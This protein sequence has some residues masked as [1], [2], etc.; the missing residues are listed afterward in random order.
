MNGRKGGTM[1]TS[2]NGIKLIEQFEGCKL[3]AYKDSV[4]IW[5]IGYGHTKGVTKGMKITQA[6]AN[7]YLRQDVSTAESA[8]NS[9]NSIYNFSQNQFDA[10]VSFTFNCGA[11][12]LKTLLQN[13]SRSLT[14]VGEKIPLYSKAGGSTLTGLVR[15]RAAEQALFNKTV[16]NTNKV[17]EEEYNMQTIKKGSRGNAVK[18][19]QIIVGEKA[20][21]IFGAGTERSTKT[22]QS[23]HGLSTDGIVGKKSWKAGL[24]SVN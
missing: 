22:F 10:L 23:K 12:N 3:T 2:D 1:K 20:D 11:G 16:A 21:G 15:R 14:E 8:V 17:S 7:N 5:T 24:D 19:W 6:Q 9:Y 4:G 13:G 18:I